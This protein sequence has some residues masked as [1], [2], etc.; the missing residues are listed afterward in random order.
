MLDGFG[1]DKA[2]IFSKSVFFLAMYFIRMLPFLL[3]KSE[4]HAICGFSLALYLFSNI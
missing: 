2:K 1:K 4:N 3:K